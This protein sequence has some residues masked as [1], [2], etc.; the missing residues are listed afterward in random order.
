MKKMLVAAMAL[1]LASPVA[2]AQMSSVGASNSSKNNGNGNAYAYGHNKTGDDSGLDDLFDNGG[3][4]A[5]PFSGDTS[6]SDLLP[7][8]GSDITSAVPE[9]TVYALLSVGLLG[10]LVIR[11]RRTKR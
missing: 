9:P 1:A 4:T 5:D 11:R 7:T 6:G 3:A 2:L 8:S 10:L